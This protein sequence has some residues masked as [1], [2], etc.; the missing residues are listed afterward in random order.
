MVVWAWCHAR[1]A[2]LISLLRS[3]VRSTFLCL[4]F[5]AIVFLGI[6]FFLNFSAELSSGAK[7]FSSAESES[8]GSLGEALG[9]NFDLGMGLTPSAS[10]CPVYPVA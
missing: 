6:E 5:G 2:L 7:L 9:A 4:G 10:E 8:E 1:L 3:P